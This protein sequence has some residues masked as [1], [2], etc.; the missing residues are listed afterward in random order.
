LRQI[1][2]PSRDLLATV[3]LSRKSCSIC[4][5]SCQMDVR[6]I[7]SPFHCQAGFA[8]QMLRV[9]EPTFPVLRSRC[10]PR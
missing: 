9:A 6:Q 2:S 5:L 7:S 4:Q 1:V 8:R 10:H 3:K